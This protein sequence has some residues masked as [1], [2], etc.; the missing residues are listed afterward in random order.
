MLKNEVGNDG[1]ATA[2]EKT[3]RNEGL[4]SEFS[5]ALSD[6][7]TLKV[8]AGTAL[9]AAGAAATV[10]AIKYARP[11]MEAGKAIGSVADEGALAGVRAAVNDGALAATHDATK[12]LTPA[13]DALLKKT[14]PITAATRD[15]AAKHMSPATKAI[16][17]NST[18]INPSTR[19][20]AAEGNAYFDI[21]PRITGAEATSIMKSRTAG[22]SPFSKALQVDE[23]SI[24]R[25]EIARGTDLTPTNPSDAV[26]L[27]LQDFNLAALSP[28]TSA[29]ALAERMP[30]PST[31]SD[32]AAMAGKLAPRIEPTQVAD[33]IA[34]A[35]KGA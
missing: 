34:K 33:A 27:Y 24:T 10:A 29:K 13:F 23:A 4:L 9:L 28:N 21:A 7:T 18:P 30:K 12:P 8:V 22:N 15:A 26:K 1:A 14:I 2:V 3:T 19:A 5:S 35:T 11:A 16:V 17:E 31:E 6:S 32:I 25:H 20:A